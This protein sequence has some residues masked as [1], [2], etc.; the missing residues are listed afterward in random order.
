M[1]RNQ[2]YGKAASQHNTRALREEVMDVSRLFSLKGKTAIVTGGSRGIGFALCEGLAQAGAHVVAVARSHKP[3]SP[4]S[5]G[6]IEYQSADI[7]KSLTGTFTDIAL[8][9][10]GLHVLVNA[11]GISVPSLGSSTDLEHAFNHTVDVNLRAAY[12]C[13]VAARPL[14]TAGG[15][16][17]NV[18]SIGSVIGFP[19]NPGYVAAKGGLRMM[20]KA[21]AIDYGEAGIRV[22]ALAPG[23]IRTAMTRG[24]FED[25]SLHEQRRRHTCL[26]RWG[27]VEDLVGAVI[28]L[29]SEASCYVTGQ[30]LFVDGGWT[31]KGMV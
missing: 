5:V 30:D 25:E 10:G 7:T 23:Y 22:N 3:D 20:T 2:M 8:R 14:M 6:E 31:A 28:F 12:S 18:T 27:T 4:F 19:G 13:C 29:A 11:A 1:L 24:S 16:I 21:L 17:I 9:F 26:G 15:S